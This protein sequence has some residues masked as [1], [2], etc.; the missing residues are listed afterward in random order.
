MI[1]NTLIIMYAVANCLALLI[2]ILALG[3]AIISKKKIAT[4]AFAEIVFPTFAEQ[5]V[6]IKRCYRAGTIFILMDWLLF[7]SSVTEMVNEPAETFAYWLTTFAIIWA[8]VFFI[9]I[10]VEVVLKFY[11]EQPN[12][13]I[14]V[15][16]GVGLSFRYS[17]LYFLL[18]FLV[19]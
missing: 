16:E 3:L 14:T 4:L 7:S 8:V 19:G 17:I 10:V 9:S 6:Y 13:K 2:T 5:A 1:F 11:K 12:K 15:S 18:V